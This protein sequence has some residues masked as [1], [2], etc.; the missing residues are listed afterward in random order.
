MFIEGWGSN[1][2]F[3]LKV[4]TRVPHPNTHTNLLKI[5]R[6]YINLMALRPQWGYL[7]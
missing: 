3:L 2:L 4:K 5:N 7:A 1:S 6:L